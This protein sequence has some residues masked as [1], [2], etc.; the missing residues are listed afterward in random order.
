MTDG[1]EPVAV[2]ASETEIA[3]WSNEKL[4]SDDISVQNGAIIC[5]S[6][7][8]PLMTDPQLQGINWITERE[9][10]KNLRIVQL[11]M[12]KYL[13]QVEQ[14]IQEGEPIIIENMGE[15]IDAVLEP[16]L[17][18]ATIKKGRNLII[19][20]GEKEVDYDTKFQLYL[21]TKLSNPH[22][23]PEVQAQCTMVNFTVTEKGLEEQLLALVVGKER[24][25]LEEQ[26]AALI[27][28]EN[29]F[30]VQLQDLAD[31]LLFR[32]ANAEGDILEDIELI[33]NLEET[34]KVSAEIEVKVAEGKKTGVVINKAR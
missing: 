4:P 8:W 10:Q 20:L 11:S 7:R 5:N 22:Y 3:Q 33:E 16:V 13:D 21:Q 1:I 12:P 29:D 27:K 31:N 28:A 15:A 9:S 2:L 25:D 24:P 14:C 34:K 17:A 6:A 32:L 18:R 26:R 30:K 23:I 19:K